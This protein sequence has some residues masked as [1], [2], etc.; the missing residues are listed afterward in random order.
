MSIGNTIKKFREL[1]NYTQ[2]FMAQQLNLS[3]SGY[4]KIERDE[5]ELTLNRL[6]EI[7]TILDV[8][9]QNILGFDDKNVFNLSHNNSANAIVQNQQVLSTEGWK[10]AIETLEN[11]NLH[12]KKIID[13]MM[14]S[15]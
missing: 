15:K 4:G 8:N 14:I 1:K 3:V 13:K 2:A 12:L 11:E 9:Y 6:Q 7:A 5:T 10:K